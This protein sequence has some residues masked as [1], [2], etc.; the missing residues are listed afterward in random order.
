[1]TGS[2]DIDSPTPTG[3]VVPSRDE[4][5]KVSLERLG[6]EPCR[7]QVDVCRAILSCNYKNIIS[8]AAT[9]AG[10]TVNFWTP[11][12]FQEDKTLVIVVPLKDLGQQMADLAA[13][14]RLSSVNVM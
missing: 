2:A 9:G 6:F 12:F 14:Y 1:M 5:V 7:W 11:L 3:F 10:K 8:T 13:S 4:I